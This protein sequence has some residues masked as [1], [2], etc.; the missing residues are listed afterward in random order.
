MYNQ[1][2]E[3]L[4]A[5]SD[6]DV[7][8][9]I[10]D[11]PHD[12]GSQM[13]MQQECMDI[14]DADGD[15]EDCCIVSVSAIETTPVSVPAHVDVALGPMHMSVPV[16]PALVP[17]SSRDGMPADVAAWSHLDRLDVCWMPTVYIPHILWLLQPPGFD[18]E[19]S[20][21]HCLELLTVLGTS[22]GS[23][24]IPMYRSDDGCVSSSPIWNQR[25]C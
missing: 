13:D 23:L 19:Q 12:G 11:D 8:H 17:A 5:D 20:F 25:C 18:G 10:H 3:A 6:D 14:C 2:L 7:Q 22:I 16:G 24:V 1:L 4:L 21:S 9:N 15:I